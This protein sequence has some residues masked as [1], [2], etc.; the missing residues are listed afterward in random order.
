MCSC[1]SVDTVT[2]VAIHSVHARCSIHARTATAFINFCNADAIG[3]L[4]WF[5]RKILAGKVHEIGN[6]TSSN[7]AESHNIRENLIVMKKN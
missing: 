6:H 2:R 4:I 5:R 1:V 3:T 7:S